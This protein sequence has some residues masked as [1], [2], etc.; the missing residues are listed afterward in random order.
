MSIQG[1]TPDVAAKMDVVQANVICEDGLLQR[2][3]EHG[4]RHP[5]GHVRWPV[6]DPDYRPRHSRGTSSGLG[7]NA[8]CDGCC[9][10]WKGQA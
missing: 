8:E 1:V 2:T 10:A 7:Q 6:G 9:Q 4:I 5:V 3:C